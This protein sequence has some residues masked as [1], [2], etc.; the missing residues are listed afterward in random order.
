MIKV[1]G[2][3]MLDRWIMGNAGRISPEAPVP[4]LLE[5]GQDFSVGGAGN[6]A[7]NLQSINGQ[8]ALYGSIG[9]DS[10][11][12]HLSLL[13]KDSDINLHYATDHEVT[14]TK[15]RLVGQGG[16]HIIR[17]DREEQY[18][19]K[20]AFQKLLANVIVKDCVVISDYA[21]GT[22]TK[23]TVK[24]LVRRNCT[25]FV[26]PKQAPEFYQDAFLQY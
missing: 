19:G 5:Q 1:D 18:I 7:L 25:V 17:W 13:L 8:V 2:D 21:K 26:D 11:G 14:T 10:E 3:I 15:T 4:I 20:D 12:R 24:E 16:Q 6:M 22:V 23:E 9:N